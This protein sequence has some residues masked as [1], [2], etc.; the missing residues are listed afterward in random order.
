MD[1]AADVA[2]SVSATNE[3]AFLF[4]FHGQVHQ[5]VDK[6]SVIGHRRLLEDKLMGQMDIHDIHVMF[7]DAQ[8]AG[9]KR[10][11]SH[12]CL[13][14]ALEDMHAA[15]SCCLQALGVIYYH[16]SCP[17]IGAVSLVNKTS[18][19]FKT[20]NAMSGIV[21]PVERSRVCELWSDDN[22]RPCSPAHSVACLIPRHQQN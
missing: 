20:S 18:F 12:N 4:A 22:E 8:H 2:K 16:I 9:D 11:R 14:N 3:N 7:R 17:G 6:A 15:L 5:S 1:E 21:G 19:A 13:W 10:R